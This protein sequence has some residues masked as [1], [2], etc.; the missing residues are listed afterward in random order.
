MDEKRCILIGVP[1]Q[2]GTSRLGCDMGPSAY[3]AA[4]LGGALTS[5]G[6][7]V[8]D[9]G[10]IAPPPGE[11]VAHPNPSVTNPLRLR[12]LDVGAQRGRLSGRGRGPS[13]LPRRRS[14]PLC[15]YNLGHEPAGG[16]GGPRVAR[17]L[18]RRPSRSPQPGD[19]DERQSP[20]RAH[21]L[22]TRPQGVRPLPAAARRAGETAQRLYDRPAQ[23]RSGGA[24]GRSAR[25]GSPC[26]ICA[27]STSS[28]SAFC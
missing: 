9:R 1:V 28:A 4:G 5:L 7:V 3:R 21:G 13:D 24:A 11:A 26:T 10:N 16:R 22:C 14:Q 15:R 12:A 6:L 23:R 20:R 8:E 19:D 27:P 25:P 17:A 2:E 18:A